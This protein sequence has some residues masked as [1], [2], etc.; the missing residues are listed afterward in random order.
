MKIGERNKTVGMLT[1]I[2]SAFLASDAKG[3]MACFM[4][5]DEGAFLFVIFAGNVESLMLL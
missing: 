4:Q 5:T 2:S 3:V 1:M